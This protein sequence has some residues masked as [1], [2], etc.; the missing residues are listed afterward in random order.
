MTPV[1]P[2]GNPEV[3]VVMSCYNSGRWLHEAI[4]SILAQTFSAF[5]LILVDDGSTDETWKIIQSY[6]D[7]DERIVAISKKN[8]GLADALNIGIAKARGL[9]VARLDADDLC[10][11]ARL[12]CQMNF[13]H[14]HPEVVLLGT[15]FV[16]IDE[17]GRALRRHHYPS[18]HRRLVGHLERVQRFFPHSS[19]MFRRDVAQEAGCYNPFFRKTQDWDLWLRLSER[20][21]MACLEDCLVRVRRHSQQITSSNAGTS[22]YV[23]GSVA[24]A[25]HY[26]RMQGCSDPSATDDEAEWLKFITWVEKRLGEDGVCE[27]HSVW[28]AARSE[29]LMSDNRAIGLFGLGARLLRSGHARA[30]LWE[31]YFGTMLPRRLAREWKARPC[32]A[33]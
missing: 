1:L 11:S 12:E 6:C 22:Q 31:K 27:R 14:D 15:G 26:L 8:T 16:E 20:G 2:G 30:L 21:E 5:E 23:Y 9:W 33:S 19:A 13:V 25:C 7:R 10:E 29:Y 28:A 32:A 18:R 3:S 24:S 17:Q 4:D